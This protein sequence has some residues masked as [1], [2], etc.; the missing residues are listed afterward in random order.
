VSY[1]VVHDGVRLRV[2][3]GVLSREIVVRSLVVVVLESRSA[4]QPAVDIM[5]DVTSGKAV[6]IEAW[7][8][9]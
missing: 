3:T 5:A 4:N 1:G 2:R 9:R 8:V 6:Y 7:C